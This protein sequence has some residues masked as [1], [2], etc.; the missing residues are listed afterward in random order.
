MF[1]PCAQIIPCM[2]P[3]HQV[4][5][6]VISKSGKK[7]EIGLDREFRDMP[8][9]FECDLLNTGSKKVM[10]NMQVSLGWAVTSQ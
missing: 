8:F 6:F 1:A 7:T 3:S 4:D 2:Q 5:T 9:L 10:S